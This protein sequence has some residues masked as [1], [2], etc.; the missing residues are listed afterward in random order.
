[1]SLLCTLLQIYILVVF[2][3]IVLSW[4]PIT[5]GT[6]MA[7]IAEFLF[8]ITEPVLG[9]LRRIIPPIGMIDISPIVFFFGVQLIVVPL[10]C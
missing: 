3:R 4:F 9:P 2:A 1:V 10:V 6:T 8:S 7:S 5:P